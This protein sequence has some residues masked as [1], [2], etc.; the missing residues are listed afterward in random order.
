VERKSSKNKKTKKCPVKNSRKK[1]TVKP[2]KTGKRIRIL[3]M[4]H[5]YKF[6]NKIQTEKK[7]LSFAV[8]KEIEITLEN[9]IK[10]LKMTYTKFEID[11]KT[12]FK[13]YPNMEEK[14]I[15]LSAIE[16]LQDE[17]LEEGQLF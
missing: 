14:D 10:D 7:E 1:R 17:I 15:D 3:D 6:L 2:T 5:I 9:I 11:D 12:I 16:E 4:E 13:V 8:E